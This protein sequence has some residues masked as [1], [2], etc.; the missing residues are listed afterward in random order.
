MKIS[1]QTQL[2]AQVG[3]LIGTMI[4]ILAS[5][6]F[7]IF[8]TNF[9]WYFKV[10][11]SIGEI[12]IFGMMILS[13]RQAIITRKNYLETQ[14]EMKKINE[15]ANATISDLTKKDEVSIP[16]EETLS[17]SQESDKSEEKHD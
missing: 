6:I 8:F 4:G 15:E 11:T 13:L 9:Q 12:G 7:V 16:K 10:A 1:E 14:E 17:N 3:F 5:W 2:E